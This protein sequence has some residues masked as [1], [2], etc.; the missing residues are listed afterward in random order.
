M[1]SHVG[2]MA[3]YTVEDTLSNSV[4]RIHIKFSAG[5][6]AGSLMFQGAWRKGVNPSMTTA[7]YF[8]GPLLI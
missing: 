6:L 1:L 3:D 4:L 2:Y 7:S 5:L 8:F